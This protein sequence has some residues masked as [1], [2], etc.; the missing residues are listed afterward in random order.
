LLGN[1]AVGGIVANAGGFV[2][3]KKAAIQGYEIGGASSSRT[4][5]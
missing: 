2:S 4:Q 5:G 3:P 1:R